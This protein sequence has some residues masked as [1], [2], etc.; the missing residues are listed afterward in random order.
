MMD[1]NAKT[2]SIN[3]I[4]RSVQGKIVGEIE[5]LNLYQLKVVASDE[6]E[7]TDIIDTLLEIEGVAAAFPN[8]QISDF[9]MEGTACSP[10]NDPAFQEGENKRHYEIIGMEDAW[11]IIRTSEVKLNPAYVGVLDSAL[12]KKVMSLREK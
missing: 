11:R 12:S 9:K 10:L 1:D 5:V 6:D 7:L 3:E 2:D 8:I 4:T